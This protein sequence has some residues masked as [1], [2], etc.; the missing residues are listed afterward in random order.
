MI[1]CKVNSQNI[2]Q[3]KYFTGYAWKMEKYFE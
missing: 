1:I 3:E 2:L